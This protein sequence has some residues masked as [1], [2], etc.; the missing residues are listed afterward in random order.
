[1]QRSRVSVVPSAH[2]ALCEA[3]RGPNVPALRPMPEWCLAAREWVRAVDAL[4]VRPSPALT[5]G[6]P[7]EF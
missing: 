3:L 4:P 6:V 7:L 5:D 2:A 1:M